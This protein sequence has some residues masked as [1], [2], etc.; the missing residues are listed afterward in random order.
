[1]TDNPKIHDKG[2]FHGHPHKPG[3]VASIGGVAS[4]AGTHPAGP[5]GDHS[6]HEKPTEKPWTGTDSVKG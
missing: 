6:G 1:M 3:K 4:G 2:D 5:S